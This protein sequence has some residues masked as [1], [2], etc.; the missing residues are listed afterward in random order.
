MEKQQRKLTTLKFR[1]KNW[2]GNVSDREVLPI[3]HIFTTSKW[4]GDTPQ[5]FLQAT[6]VIKCEQRLFAV[7]DIIKFY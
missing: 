1:Y 6:D 3:D 4:H 2:K 5:W 7:K